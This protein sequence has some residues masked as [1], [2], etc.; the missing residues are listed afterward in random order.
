MSN[1]KIKLNDNTVLELWNDDSSYLYDELHEG[2]TFL[3]NHRDYNGT[4][5]QNINHGT[6]NLITKGK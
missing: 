1:E 2:M 4:D 5:G 3:S 6:P